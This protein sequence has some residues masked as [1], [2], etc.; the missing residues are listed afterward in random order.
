MDIIQYQI[1][2]FD[3]IYLTCCEK[4]SVWIQV[5]GV[6]KDVFKFICTQYLKEI[7]IIVWIKKIMNRLKLN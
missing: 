3:M 1:F 5:T 2:I 7:I 6:K 4:E